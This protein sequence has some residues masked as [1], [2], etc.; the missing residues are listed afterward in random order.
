MR[1]LVFPALLALCLAPIGKGVASEQVFSP[2]KGL[3]VTQ[4]FEAQRK[5][6]VQ[7]L[8]D[9]E[10]YSEISPADL[11]TVNTSL[12]RM[13]QLLDGVQDVAQLRG[14][15]RV[16]LFNEQ[17]Q[18]NTLLTRAHDDSRMI[19]RRE[20]PTGSNRPTNTCM[21]VAQRRRARDGAQDTMRYHPRAQE[22]AETR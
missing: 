3:D 5:L 18:I 6:L 8:N 2:D 4:S 22:R 10:T 12:A 20:K 7:A 9:G 19:C 13:S 14:A 15:A 11:Q 16:E 21:T 1:M 17:E